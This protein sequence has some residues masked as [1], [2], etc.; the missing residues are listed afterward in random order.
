MAIVG[1]TFI[2]LATTFNLLFMGR[3]TGMS[4]VVFTLIRPL[5]DGTIA[6]KF[7]FFAGLIGISYLSFLVSPDGKIAGTDYII[8]DTRS[9]SYEGQNVGVFMIGGLLVGI[10]VKLGNGCTSGHAVC[11]VPRLSMRSIIAT[12]TFLMFGIG[13]STLRGYYSY[14]DQ[15]Q[16]FGNDYYTAFRIVA[17]ILVGGTILVF[18]AHTI[19]TF[20][21]HKGKND[22]IDPL[23][24]FLV[25]ILFGAGLT[26]SGMQRG[27]KIRAFLTLKEG[28]D[29]S[30]IFVMAS[31]VGIN[32]ITFQYI[33]R[34]V[35]KPVCKAKFGVPTNTKIEWN[36][37][38]GPAIFGCGWGLSG[39][40]PGPAMCNLFIMTHM[41]LFIPFMIMGIL[42][43]YYG[44]NALQSYLKK[45]SPTSPTKEEITSSAGADVMKG[46]YISILRK[47]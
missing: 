46:N 14:L 47:R 22:R 27:T 37:F 12:I 17:D 2:A 41:I 32:L 43:S 45:N 38:V 39:F 44:M 18:I 29:P 20:I 25:G 5:V 16:G 31:A 24:S 28:W 23:F 9:T 7:N 19:Y 33:L 21:K 11:G 42:I 6:W 8:F 40:C 30:L 13:M 35:P 3:I 36:L 10:G 15:D 26:I 4:S 1:G 34:K